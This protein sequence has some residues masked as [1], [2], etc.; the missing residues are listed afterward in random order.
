[1]LNHITTECCTT[2]PELLKKLNRFT[3]NI[4]QDINLLPVLWQNKHTIREFGVLGT[5]GIYTSHIFIIRFLFILYACFNDK[6]NY[7]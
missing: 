1:M 7:E 4:R 2:I 5:E 6:I 3:R